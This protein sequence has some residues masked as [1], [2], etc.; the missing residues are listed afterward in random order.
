MWLGIGEILPEMGDRL[1]VVLG[2]ARPGTGGGDIPLEVNCTCEL[3][4]GACSCDTGL[5][6]RFGLRAD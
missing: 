6:D 3:A 4:E 2:D 5:A 1:P